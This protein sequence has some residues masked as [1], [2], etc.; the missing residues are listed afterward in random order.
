MGDLPRST[1]RQTQPV[2]NSPTVSDNLPS[3]LKV[4]VLFDPNQH[5]TIVVPPSIKYRTLVDRIDSKMARVSPSSIARG[6]ARLRYK[7]ADDDFVA[8]KTD[9]DVVLAIEE[10]ASIHEQRIRQ[11]VI[12]DFE[13]FWQEKA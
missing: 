11:G 8:I 13:L 3:Q 7:D 12:N 10:W 5:V 4:K 6:T 1:P 2:P 9:E